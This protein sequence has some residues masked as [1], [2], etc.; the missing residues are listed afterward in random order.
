MTLGQMFLHIKILLLYGLVLAGYAK[1]LDEDGED[2]KKSLAQ[3]VL[4]LNVLEKFSP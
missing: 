2:E 3:D 1:H 4:K